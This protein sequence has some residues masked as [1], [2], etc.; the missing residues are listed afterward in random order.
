MEP[1]LNLVAL[2]EIVLLLIAA[3]VALRLAAQR[4]RLPPAAAL[5]LGGVALALLP[6]VR[7]IELDPDFTL[8]LFLP[9]LLMASAYLTNWRDFRADLRIILQLAVGAVLFTTLV[10]GLVTHWLLPALPCGL[11][12]VRRHRLAAG[13]GG[14]EGRAARVATAATGRHVAGGREPGQ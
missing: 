1:A 6:G 12:C 14:G 11:L 5:I 9:P 4:L 13:C 3:S 7:D 2:F 10:V 8:V